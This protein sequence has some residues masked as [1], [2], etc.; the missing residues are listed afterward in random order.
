M[1]SKKARRARSL[2]NIFA[3]RWSRERTIAPRALT[4]GCDATRT[5]VAALRNGKA[6]CSFPFQR[7]IH[8]AREIAPRT[9]RNGS[10]RFYYT[11]LKPSRL[12]LQSYRSERP[13]FTTPWAAADRPV[14]NL[15][16]SVA[17]L[18][19]RS[20]EKIDWLPKD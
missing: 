10:R 8:S 13:P 1:P 14:E 17:T 15:A 5:R 7:E 4:S 11:A 19:S 3:S 16:V 18:I 9:K 12:P 20:P 6:R 2:T